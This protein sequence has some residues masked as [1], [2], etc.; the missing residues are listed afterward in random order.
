MW[1]LLWMTFASLEEV[2][3]KGELGDSSLGHKVDSLLLCSKTRRLL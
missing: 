2:N 1:L 3:L